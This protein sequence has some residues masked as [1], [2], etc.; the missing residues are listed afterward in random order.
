MQTQ[1]QSSGRSALVDLSA[2]G[3]IVA[4]VGGVSFLGL[5]GAAPSMP[6]R[7]LLLQVLF[8]AAGG[9]IAA[10]LVIT[11]YHIHEHM[12]THHAKSLPV[13]QHCR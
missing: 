11:L 4:V 10:V 13:T 2:F 9:L 8:G 6:L 5:S 12:P 7:E 3:A 1:K